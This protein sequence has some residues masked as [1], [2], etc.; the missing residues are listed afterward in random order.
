MDKLFFLLYSIAVLVDIILAGV[1]LVTKQP[2]RLQVCVV[3]FPVLIIGLI[4]Q[5]GRVVYDNYW[6][7]MMR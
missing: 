7:V 3:I 4:T 6:L 2:D 1:Y 5:Y